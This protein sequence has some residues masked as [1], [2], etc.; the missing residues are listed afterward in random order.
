[1]KYINMCVYVYADTLHG[2]IFHEH[3]MDFAYVRE[4]F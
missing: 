4:Y 2:K 1:M 3:V